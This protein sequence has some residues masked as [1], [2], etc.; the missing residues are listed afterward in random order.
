M[1]KK[2][3]HD[4]NFLQVVLIKFDFRNY[5]FIEFIENSYFLFSLNKSK[6]LRS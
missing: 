2:F 1:K 5:P 3:F 4:D 6:G